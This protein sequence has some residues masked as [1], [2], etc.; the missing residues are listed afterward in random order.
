MTVLVWSRRIREVDQPVAV[1]SRVGEPNV[2]PS[3]VGRAGRVDPEDLCGRP[4]PR[5][6]TSRPCRRSARPRASTGIRTRA[7]DDRAGPRRAGPRRRRRGGARSRRWSRARSGR[8][9]G[10][11]SRVRSDG[12]EGDEGAHARG[13]AAERAVVRK[14]FESG[15]PARTLLRMILRMSSLFVRTLRDDPADAEVP[16]HRLLVR[17]GLHPPRRPGDLHLAAAGAAGAAQDRGHHPRRDGR[18]RRPGAAVPRAAAPG[19]LRGDAA[20][21]PSTATASSGS[22]TA[23]TTTTCSGRPTRRC[24]P[25]W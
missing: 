14:P 25:S 20:A 5:R 15:L 10:G 4:P 1:R 7:V 23:R 16:S 21:G 8:G 9:R 11:A 6:T 22:R 13:D 24:S 3:R 18:D 17:A 19:A 12:G 2:R